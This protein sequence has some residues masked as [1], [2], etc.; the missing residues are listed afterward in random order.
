MLDLIEVKCLTHTHTG[1]K[2]FRG[3]QQSYVPWS[4][5]RV[6]LGG[7]LPKAFHT[8]ATAVVFRERAWLENTTTSMHLSTPLR[9]RELT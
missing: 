6:E 1:V 2:I 7:A 5:S 3:H 9:H 4:Q 8:G